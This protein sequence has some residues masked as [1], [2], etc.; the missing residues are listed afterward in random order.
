MSKI[1]RT[2]DDFFATA[3]GLSGLYPYQR[4]LATNASLPELLGV[5]T[6]VGKTATISRSTTMAS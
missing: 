5:P 6:C 3:T 2:F 1:H 4:E